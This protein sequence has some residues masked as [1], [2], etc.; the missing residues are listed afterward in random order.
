MQIG[1]GMP[2]SPYSHIISLVE[3]LH[4]VRPKSILDI[5]LGNGKLGFIARDFLD[6][7]LGG[8]YHKSKWQLQL[9]GIEVCRD[10]IQDHQKAV[11]DDIFIG[12]AYEVIDQ[13]GRYDM[14]LMGDVLEHFEKQRGLAFMDKCFQH[15]G[16]AI[17]LFIPLGDGWSQEDI[18]GNPYETHLS[19]WEMDELIPICT[20]HRLYRYG[21]GDYGAFLLDKDKYIEKRIENLKL[22]SNH[23]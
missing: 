12:D 13:L 5:G 22:R 4:A 9:D 10:Y 3:Y 8:Q 7:M 11:Y 2:T 19:T 18:Y 23:G 6:V 16:E 1:A 15:A 20:Q 21:P 17:G 14:I